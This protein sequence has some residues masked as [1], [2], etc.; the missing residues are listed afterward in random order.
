MAQVTRSPH[1]SHRPFSGIW[2]NVTMRRMRPVLVAAGTVGAGRGLA[3][4]G[5][6]ELLR[7]QAA[8]ARARIGKPLGE[9][10]LAADKVWKK[11]SYDGPPVHLLVLGIVLPRP[12]ADLVQRRLHG[13]L[14]QLRKLG[15][16]CDWE[17]ARFTMDAGLSRAV[18][19]VF[20][21]LYEKGL[22]YRGNYIINWCPRCLTALSNE[23]A[24]GEETAGTLWHIRYP[25]SDGQGYINVATT[26]PETLLGDVAV[27]V[28]P[29]RDVRAGCIH[30]PA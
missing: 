1:G 23:E 7:R 28:H 19:E 25:L 24:E 12:R 21:R 14:D 26:R 22:I 10:A 8:I 13:G 11:K 29:D 5:G 27:A 15:A 4:T 17:R 3:T 6:R 2:F 18:R 30:R 16:S 20:V 9:E